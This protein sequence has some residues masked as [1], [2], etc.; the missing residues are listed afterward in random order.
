MC[1]SIPAH[2]SANHAVLT[3]VACAVDA[4]L[5]R[6]SSATAAAAAAAAVIAA[7]A[8]GVVGTGAGAIVGDLSPTRHPL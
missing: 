3:L 8:A 1:G 6:S 5:A 4:V 2:L 7:A